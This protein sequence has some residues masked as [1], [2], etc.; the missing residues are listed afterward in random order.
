ITRAERGCAIYYEGSF[1]E[2]KGFE[3]SVADTVGAGDAFAAAFLHGLNEGW[4]MEQVGKFA[5]AAG[6]LVASRAGATPEWTLDEC[7]AL[8]RSSAVG[9]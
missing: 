9:A 5:N 8:S 6:A 4:T 1:V 3:V 2:V 7:L